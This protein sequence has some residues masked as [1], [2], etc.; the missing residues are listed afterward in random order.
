MT[1]VEPNGR[2]IDE[3][4]KQCLPYTYAAKDEDI[5]YMLNENKEHV[6]IIIDGYKQTIVK[7]EFD[8]LISGSSYLEDCRL[9]V[10][11]PS[12]WDI[13]SS[14]LKLFETKLLLHGLLPNQRDNLIQ[15]Y[16]QVA[17]AP[18]EFLAAMD[19]ALLTNIEV[20]DSL[21]LNPFLCL[22]LCYTVH[23]SIQPAQTFIP[24]K[25]CVAADIL[26]HFVMVKV[27]R[28]VE[29]QLITDSER[30]N[31]A[32]QSDIVTMGKTA[33]D[34]A[35]TG[36]S[37]VF[38][39]NLVRDK[40]EQI[41]LLEEN[42]SVKS[43]YLS[44]PTNALQW[45]LAAKFLLSD[46]SRELM[47]E[48]LNT[49]TNQYR[50]YHSLLVSFVSQCKQKDI[51]DMIFNQLIEQCEKSIEHLVKKEPPIDINSNKL[52]ENGKY[53][54]SSEQSKDAYR[55]EVAKLVNN[56]RRI[57]STLAPLLELLHVSSEGKRFSERIS[58]MFSGK[59]AIKSH[60]IHNPASVAGLG[61]CLSEESNAVT[62]V[63]VTLDFLGNF[64]D[65]TIHRLANGIAQSKMVTTLTLNFTS[66]AL[67]ARFLAT[68]FS[69]ESSAIKELFLVD[70]G[71]KPDDFVSASM[72]TDLKKAATKMS[73]VDKIGLFNCKNPNLVSFFIE[74]M[75][76]EIRDVHIKNCALNLKAIRQ[77]GLLVEKSSKL[78]MLSLSGSHI[79]QID[80]N[81][82]VLGLKLAK[83]LRILD[84]SQTN[85]EVASLLSLVEALEFN[86]SLT[87]LN[88]SHT[89]LPT[90]VC[91]KMSHYLQNS[92][93]K[94]ITLNKCKILQVDF[95]H[96]TEE[97]G[98]KIR[99]IGIP[100]FS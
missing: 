18:P 56:N 32:I 85:V 92:S 55:H 25:I 44:F 5:E 29:R 8:E 21:S 78:N 52:H 45:F 84:I 67:L 77:I 51:N 4:R 16:A 36:T 31:K 73:K 99:F 12:D 6:L 68:C 83:T 24:P 89:V 54:S 64:Y 9:L 82:L 80:F 69:S 10:T 74:S 65:D 58:A 1:L 11:T 40:D 23:F 2:L 98:S 75:P 19:S 26:N 39:K 94:Q 63:V 47:E 27:T 34:M 13:T 66:A 71:A 86:T 37:T 49:L 22:C 15:L 53:S 61:M 50:K 95:Q 30:I 46:A 14:T 100:A 17:N 7:S 91:L 87:H 79:G 41:I 97:F 76:A 60:D 93:L 43:D 70:E 33:L 88:I 42:G 62:D 3:I 38:A 59:L 35:M 96:F 28:H 20:S 57:F 90:S 48:H 72:W 81:H